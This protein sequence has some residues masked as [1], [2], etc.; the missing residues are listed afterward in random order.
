MNPRPF[1]HASLNNI[2]IGSSIFGSRTDHVNVFKSS[3]Y[4]SLKNYLSP[5]PPYIIKY[6]SA[7]IALE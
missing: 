6:L 4:Q 5:I 2:F 7:T 1:D 3:K